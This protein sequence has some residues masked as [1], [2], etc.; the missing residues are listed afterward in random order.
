MEPG[1]GTQRNYRGYCNV[2]TCNDCNLH[3]NGHCIQRMYGNRNSDR[4]GEPTTD[5][6]SISYI[7]NDMR[8]FINHDYRVRRGCLQLE[9]FKRIKQYEWRHCFG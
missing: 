7:T 9:S 2:Y 6:N 4:N 8:W 3:G 1:D 5:H